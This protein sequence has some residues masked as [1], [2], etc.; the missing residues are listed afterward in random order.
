MCVVATK[1]LTSYLY[2]STGHMFNGD[3]LCIWV[4]PNL[5]KSFSSINQI[6]LRHM[7]SII[8]DIL[9]F[10]VMFLSD[11]VSL[12]VFCTDKPHV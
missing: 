1:A 5:W 7:L 3:T 8:N 12:Y 6:Q 2:T 11:K 9:R 10:L 4:N